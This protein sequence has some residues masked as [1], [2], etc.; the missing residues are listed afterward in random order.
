MNIDPNRLKEDDGPGNPGNRPKSEGEISMDTPG[1][2]EMCGTRG[3]TIVEF[4]RWMDAKWGSF[5]EVG[6]NGDVEVEGE[7]H[8]YPGVE[9]WMRKELGFSGEDI[10]KIREKLKAA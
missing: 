7:E 6:E 1:M 4:L 5:A 8:K 9:G 3:E 2:E 10:K